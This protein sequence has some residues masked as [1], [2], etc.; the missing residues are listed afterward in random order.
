MDTIRAAYAPI[1]HLNHARPLRFLQKDLT[2][3]LL[4]IFRLARRS[5]AG[6]DE[7]NSVKCVCRNHFTNYE[8]FR[9]ILKFR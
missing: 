4:A 9:Y 5:S 6:M 3:E 8:F 7:P 1:P 2:E